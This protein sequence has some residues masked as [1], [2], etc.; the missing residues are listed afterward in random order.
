MA[1]RGI[2][3]SSTYW[4]QLLSGDIITYQLVYAELG[5]PAGDPIRL[6][7]A[8]KNITMTGAGD[9]PGTY[10]AAGGL[11]ALSSYEE[12]IRLNVNT[13]KVSLEGV[14][15][16]AISDLLNFPYLDRTV[17]IWQGLLD[18]N[19][20]PIQD[21]ILLLDGRISGASIQDD[22]LQGTSKVSVEVSSQWA[23][24]ERK[25]GTRTN[26]RDHQRQYPNDVG[27]EFA[28]SSKKHIKWGK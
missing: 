21:V 23:D 14:T 27:F 4:N 18:A 1:F 17:K 28:A 11:L 9:L 3:P 10:N 16:A 7:N 15:G 22:T 5:N 2:T 19:S 6:T 25:G 8:Y 24:F 20:D 13:L 26:D 12:S